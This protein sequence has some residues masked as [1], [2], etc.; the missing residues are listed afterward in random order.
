MILPFL[1]QNRLFSEKTVQKLAIYRLSITRKPCTVRAECQ[2][3]D[4]E[5]GCFCEALRRNER[6]SRNNKTG[7]L[8]QGPASR[9][10]S[11]AEKELQLGCPWPNFLIGSV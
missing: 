4:L 9:Y 11:N 3:R 6:S 8:W 2:N 1:T 7:S 5:S 10:K